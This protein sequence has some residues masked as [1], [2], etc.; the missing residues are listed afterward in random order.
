MD[1]NYRKSGKSKGKAIPIQACKGS[2]GSRRV[3][4]TDFMTVGT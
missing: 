4:T 3:K 2:E 1:K